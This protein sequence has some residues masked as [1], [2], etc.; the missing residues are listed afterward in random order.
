MAFNYASKYTVVFDKEVM[1]MVADTPV[2]ANPLEF[3]S[4]DDGSAWRNFS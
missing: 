2:L 4:D 1:E 3:G